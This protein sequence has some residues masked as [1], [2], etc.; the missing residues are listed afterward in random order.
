MAREQDVFGG[1]PVLTFNREGDRRNFMKWAGIIGVGSTFA[2]A[3][4]RNRF[5][6]AQQVP[7]SD[8]EILNYALTLEFLE[9]DF[10]SRGLE[11]DVLSGRELELVQPI[12]DHEEAHVTQL[13]S[14]IS[15]LG[16]EPVEEPQFNYPGGTFN[17]KNA[18]LQ[19]AVTFEE[20]G[21]DA[22]HGQ[23]TRIKTVDI[24]A[25]AAAIAGVESRHAAILEDMTGGEPFPAP[26]EDNKSMQQVLEAAGEFIQS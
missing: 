10:Y 3:G 19:T 9:A 8:I 17:Q 14:T 26:V 15:D 23:V 11:R 5:A 18:F 25:A 22:Y 7:N 16:G 13:T 12:R 2:V 6:I 24:L 4:A 21:V 20:L 1:Q